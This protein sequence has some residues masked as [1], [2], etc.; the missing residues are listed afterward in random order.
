MPSIPPGALYPG[1]WL[2]RYELLCPVA[3]GGMAQVWVARMQTQLGMQRLV[4]VKA[5]LAEHADDPRFHAMFLD[6]ARIISAV[7]HPNVAQILDL[8]EHA[9]VLYHVLEW[10]EGDSLAALRRSVHRKKHKLPLGIV[11][12]VAAATCAGLHAAHEVRDETGALLGVVHRDVSPANVLLGT[13][14]EVKLID[15]GVAKA[16]GR[17]AEETSAGTIKGRVAYMSPEQAMGGALDRRADVWSMGAML[18]QLLAGR[19]PYDAENQLAML[20]LLSR[21]LPPAPLRDVPADVAEIVYTALSYNPAGRFHTAEE[22]QRTIEDAM[23]RHC[24]PVTG[25]DVAHFLQSELG[26]RIAR[27]RATIT[28]AIEAAEQRVEIANEYEVAS[29]TAS[30]IAASDLHTPSTGSHSVVQ[31][32]SG[33]DADP[34]PALEPEAPPPELDLDIDLDRSMKAMGARR[35]LKLVVIGCI[36]LLALLGYAGYMAWIRMTM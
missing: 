5:I 28:R 15:F 27:R 25:A 36:A 11:L 33:P 34:V 7:H 12:R 23:A 24:A 13:S 22:M 6:E 20:H 26:E 31:R 3:Q 17:M 16:M 1:E 19:V 10:V 21:G 9:S 29:A 32:I 2:D 18:Y 4:A 30:S 8:G 35:H 14:G